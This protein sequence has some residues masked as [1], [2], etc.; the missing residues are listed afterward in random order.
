MRRNEARKLDDIP[1]HY[2]YAILAA[3][4]LKFKNKKEKKGDHSKPESPAVMQGSLDCHLNSRQQL[5]TKAR[6][7]RVNGYEREL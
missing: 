4:L 7:L 1:C 5:E 2:L 6:E 3:F